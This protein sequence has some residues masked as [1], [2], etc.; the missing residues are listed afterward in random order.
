MSKT[1]R[2]KQNRQKALSGVQEREVL[3]VRGYHPRIPY[4]LLFLVCCLIYSNTLWNDYAIDDAIVLTD[5]VFTKKGV[6]GI[7]DLLTHDAFEGYFGEKGSTL[8]Q[9]GRYRPLSLVSFAI[10]YQFWGLTPGYSHAINVLLFAFTC[11]LIFY[12]LNML[13]VQQR[14]RAFFLGWPFVAALLYAVHPIHTE[15]VANIKGRDEVMAMLLSVAALICSVQYARTNKYSKLLVATLLYSLALLSKENS[16]TF[17][18]ILPLTYYVFTDANKRQYFSGVAAFLAPAILFVILRSHYSPTGV[19]QESEEILNNPFLL[20]STEQRFATIFMSWIYYI[21]LLFIPYPL[22]HDYYYNQVPYV[23]FSSVS[24]MGS[25]ILHAALLAYGIKQTLA[26]RVSGYAILFYFITFSIVSNLLF[27]VGTL[28][29]ERFLFMPS[30][31]FCIVMGWLLHRRL[32]QGKLTTAVALVLVISVCSLFAGLSF[33]RNFA[34]ENNFVLLKTDVPTSP[35]SAKART[36]YG[37]LLIEEADKAS[38]SAARRSLLAESIDNLN[39]AIT[40]YPENSTTWILLGNALYKYTRDPVKA[41]NAYRNAIRYAGNKNTENALFNISLV[42]IENNMQQEARENLL[43]VNSLHPGQYKYLLQLGEAYAGSGEPD[44]AIY[45]YAQ[46]LQAKP[47]DALATY[48]I[49]VTYARLMNQLDDGL[50]WLQK[51]VEL[52]PGNIVYLEDLAVANGISGNID[53]SI[54][55]ALKM[56]QINPD[57][58]PAYNILTTAYLKKG[59]RANYL[60]YLQKAQSLQ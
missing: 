31:G 21:K 13:A 4:I 45:W 7:K 50:V 49:G 47:G 37:G 25:L 53:A 30:L 6:D 17:L 16:I 60:L 51:A 3:G 33:Q 20:A 55:N 18:A 2:N 41:V 48:K 26:K 27:S 32:E 29:N 28:V 52:E 43:L 8:I 44:S 54:S 58:L 11:M 46:A 40:I 24:A 57:Y 56:I 10:E 12:L 9:G 23:S 59:D 42:Q 15:A 38:D 39:A 35:N 22:T 36:T 19:L 34:W 14:D 5:N 1:S